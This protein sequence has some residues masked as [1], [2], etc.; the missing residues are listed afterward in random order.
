MKN[1]CPNVYITLDKTTLCNNTSD[2]VYFM[3]PLTN[4]KKKDFKYLTNDFPCRNLTEITE[5]KTE[6]S[7]FYKT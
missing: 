7:K 2:T 5:I 1:I 6:R 3:M 4:R